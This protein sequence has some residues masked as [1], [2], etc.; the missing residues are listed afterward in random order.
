MKKKWLFFQVE[1]DSAI[2]RIAAWLQYVLLL[3]SYYFY[4]MV[5]GRKKKDTQGMVIGVDEVA[6]MLDGLS[7]IFPHATMVCLSGHPFYARKYAYGPYH[8]L[9]RV[10]L[11]PL[12]LGKLANK[13]EV[14]V[15]IWWKGFLLNRTLE[16]GFLKRRKKK[17]VL[18]FCGSEIRSVEL[19]KKYYK[20]INEDTYLNY[21]TEEETGKEVEKIRIAREADDY[22]TVIFNWEI[23][24]I[25]YIKKKTYPWPYV[26]DVKEVNYCFNKFSDK[27][28]I[29]VLHV[30]GHY[31]IKG[32]PLVRAAIKKLKNEGY[33]FEYRELHKVSHDVVLQNLADSHIVLSEFYAEVPGVFGV[34]AMATGN[35]VLVSADQ[36]IVSSLGKVD[37]EA[38]VTTRYWQIY[39]HLK[40]LLDRPEQIE[41]YAK[42]GRLYVENNF[43]IE[44]SRRKYMSILKEN[45]IIIED[46]D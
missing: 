28:D 23:D 34:E 7:L 4:R 22:A 38:W 3:S 46:N 41:Q 6:N 29:V 35:A 39:D 26:I 16:L 30:P 45:D 14:F 43:S 44:K 17:I 18:I 9:S 2:L 5:A 11:A 1:S 20:K 21:L 40:S 42:A 19:T 13:N 36:E 37:R 31:V 15:Y 32:T 27:G 25:S 24:Q 33:I 10:I 8:I 12:I